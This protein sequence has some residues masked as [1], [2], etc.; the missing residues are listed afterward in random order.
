MSELAIVTS[1]IHIHM[2]RQFNEGGRRLK[3]GIWYLNYLFRLAEGNK[4]KYILLPGDLLNNMQVI[5]TKV[6]NALNKCFSDNFKAHPEIVIIAVSGN[7]DYADQNLLDASG[8]SALESFATL[9]PDNFILLDSEFP[10]YETL[11]GNVI[12]GVPYYEHAEHFRK[13]LEKVCTTA[14]SRHNSFLLMH[15]SVASGLPID[16]D[17]EATNP[18]FDKFTA[19]FNGHI[20]INQQIT[21][22]FI[23]VGSPMHRDASDI[24][25]TK[26]FWLVDLDDPL[27]TISFKETTEK[28]PQFIHV[29]VGE[30]LTEWES[31]QYVIR[32]PN[33]VTDNVAEK[34][35]SEKFRSDLSPKTLLTNYCT[36]VI[37]KEER[38]EKLT[39][40]ISLL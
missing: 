11:T 36:E 27:S 33:T 20:H 12:Y 16:D 40:V 30:E 37:P 5:A 34:Q 24:G 1:D 13:A 10:I 23:N 32:V 35:L 29:P 9:F 21:D 26:G 4:I 3:Y 2:Y 18:L 19:V 6:V 15:Q 25:Q 14:S 17:I 22:K 7:H 39:F 28:F 8:E 38:E 31:Q